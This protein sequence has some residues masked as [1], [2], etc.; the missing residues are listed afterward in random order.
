MNKLI[1]KEILENHVTLQ[2]ATK[3]GSVKNS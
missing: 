3:K 1:I 2:I